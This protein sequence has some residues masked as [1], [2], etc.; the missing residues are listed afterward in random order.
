MYLVDRPQRLLI[1]NANFDIETASKEEDDDFVQQFSTRLKS[2]M[3]F[4]VV[5]ICVVTPYALNFEYTRSENSEQNLEDF[6]KVV[7]QVKTL[8]ILLL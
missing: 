4:L 1:M 7:D 8:Q 5:L 6:L 2:M 3:I